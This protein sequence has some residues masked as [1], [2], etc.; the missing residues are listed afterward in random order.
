MTTMTDTPKNLLPLA[1]PQYRRTLAGRI[2]GWLRANLFA[3]ITSTVISLLLILV[4]AKALISLVLWDLEC[5]LDC[6]RRSNRRLPGDPRARCLL[7]RHSREISLH[8]VWHL[9]VQRAMAAGV[10]NTDL[11]RAVLSVEP[12]RHVGQKLVLLWAG[13][14][15]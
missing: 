6:P 5:D 7:G 9:S 1:R 4:L 12:P 14:L 8:S 13:A 15:V 3:S 10:G 2:I 11:H